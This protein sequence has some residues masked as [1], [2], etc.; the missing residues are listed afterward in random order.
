M[1]SSANQRIFFPAMVI[2]EEFRFH[3]E[4]DPLYG[5]KVG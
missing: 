4:P 5:I 2:A 1:I 3:D